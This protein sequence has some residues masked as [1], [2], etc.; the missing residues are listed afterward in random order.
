VT[1]QNSAL[2]EQNAATAKNL[3]QQS[4]AMS[5]SVGVFKL[6]GGGET[7]SAPKPVVRSAASRSSAA[8]RSPA[9][10]MQGGLATALK[11]EQ[12]FEEF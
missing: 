2:V 10:R 11:A 4:A 9:R 8:I 6:H 1:Q 5:T 3:Q 12:E 7:Y